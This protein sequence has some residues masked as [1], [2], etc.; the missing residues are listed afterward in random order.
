MET[1]TEPMEPSEQFCPM[2]RVAQEA[3]QDRAI[4]SFMIVS[5]N[6]IA[7]RSVNRHLV[8]GEGPCWGAEEADRVDRHGRHVACVW[9]SSTR[10]REAHLGSMSA[11]SP[12]GEIGQEQS[13]NACK[14]RSC[15]QER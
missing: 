14:K 13:R 7:A 10:H 11:Q 9:L 3:K 15:S 5:G 1:T 12:L 2:W 8:R 4:S 6:A